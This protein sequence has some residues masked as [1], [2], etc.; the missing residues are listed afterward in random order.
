[1]I[2]SSRVNIPMDNFVIIVAA[3]II[4]LQGTVSDAK[5]Y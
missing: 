4:I 2:S 3:G 5:V 1:M